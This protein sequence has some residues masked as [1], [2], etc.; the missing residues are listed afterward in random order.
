MKG[1]NMER[2]IK[3]STWRMEENKQ[4]I[5]DEKTFETIDDVDW[6]MLIGA[7]ILKIREEE[8]PEHHLVFTLLLKDQ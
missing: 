6:K 1:E 8:D 4:V 7:K 2:E 5:M 3:I